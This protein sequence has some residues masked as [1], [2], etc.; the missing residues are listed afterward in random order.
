MSES[1]GT[2]AAAWRESDTDWAPDR[3]RREEGE[4]GQGEE[5]KRC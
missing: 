5:E 4:G 2:C 1:I 3:T